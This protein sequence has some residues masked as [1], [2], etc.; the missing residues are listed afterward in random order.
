VASEATVSVP[1]D[2]MLAGTSAAILALV[3]LIAVAGVVAAGTPLA[4]LGVVTLD[5]VVPQPAA[6]KTAVAETRASV[7][8]ATF[9]LMFMSNLLFR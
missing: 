2:L 3:A 4:A 8:P 5:F 7:A 9:L 1:F 6:T